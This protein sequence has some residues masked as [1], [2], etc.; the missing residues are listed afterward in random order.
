MIFGDTVEVSVT[1]LKRVEVKQY[2]VKMRYSGEV[3]DD[4]SKNLYGFYSGKPSTTITLIRLRR[5]KE[6]GIDGFATKHPDSIIE[7]LKSWD[8]DWIIIDDL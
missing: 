3:I 6:A 1:N 8:S 7:A 5:G 2:L 4:F